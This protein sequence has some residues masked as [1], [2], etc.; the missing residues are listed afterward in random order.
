[1]CA[2][3]AAQLTDKRHVC[4]TVSRRGAYFW[5]GQL[6]ATKCKKDGKAYVKRVL[7]SERGFELLTKCDDHSLP[8]QC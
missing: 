7:G 6:F 2:S 4:V 1:M 3:H 8:L 5:D